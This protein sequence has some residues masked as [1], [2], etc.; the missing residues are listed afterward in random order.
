MFTLRAEYV[1]VV[2]VVAQSDG[3]VVT[4]IVEYEELGTGD[5]ERAQVDASLPV[6]S[7][8][9]NSTHAFSLTQ[10]LYESDVVVSVAATFT[11][12]N[13]E[14]HACPYQPFTNE[15]ANNY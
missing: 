4:S 1:V 12:L 9:W 13:G 10:N 6:W 11:F 3:S 5:V 8:A 15:C 2:I 14:R 7:P